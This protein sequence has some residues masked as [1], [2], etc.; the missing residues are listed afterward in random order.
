MD[1]T[2]LELP[3]SYDPIGGRIIDARGR[4]IAALAPEASDD[5]AL[6]LLR[7]TNRDG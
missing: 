4:E 2:T 3:L 6:E 1:T 7:L 5:V